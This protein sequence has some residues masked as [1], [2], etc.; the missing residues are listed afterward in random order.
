LDTVPDSGVLP[1][2]NVIPPATPAP[3]PS[4][5]TPT[6]TLPTLPLA[7]GAFFASYGGSPIM[8]RDAQK[9]AL[10]AQMVQLKQ[11]YENM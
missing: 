11:A 3:A 7:Q 4:P 1:L 6:L 9:K 5:A 8:D 2:A 10:A